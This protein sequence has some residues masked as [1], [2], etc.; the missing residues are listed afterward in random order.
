MCAVDRTAAWMW[1]ARNKGADH[2]AIW[3]CVVGFAV[4]DMKQLP[5]GC[6]HANA[7]GGVLLCGRCAVR[8]TCCCSGTWVRE[9]WCVF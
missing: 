5:A 7:A 9:D 4:H 1:V 8:P 3:L 2:Q 6:E